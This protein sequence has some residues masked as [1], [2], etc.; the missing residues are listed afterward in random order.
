[1]KQEMVKFWALLVLSIF[2]LSLVPVAI[3]NGDDDMDDDDEAF[4]DSRSVNSGKGKGIVSSVNGIDMKKGGSPDDNDLAASQDKVKKLLD[5]WGEIQRTR[6]D[7]IKYMKEI[8]NKESF[9]NGHAVYV[10]KFVV[11][12]TQHIKIRLESI[13]A[14]MSKDAEFIKSHPKIL[15]TIKE[16]VAKD[17]AVEQVLM[18]ILSDGTVTRDEWTQQAVPAFKSIRLIIKEIK[19]NKDFGDWRERRSR[20]VAISVA[21]KIEKKREK[22]KEAMLKKNIDPKTIEERMK[23]IDDEVK[24]LR[25]ASQDGPES[26][27][28]I[29][30]SL[31]SIKKAL[32]V[33]VMKKSIKSADS[34]L[35]QINEK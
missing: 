30:G 19:N 15:S 34:K 23:L 3:A 32:Q 12:V 26:E 13:A 17:M 24:K 11:Y 18:G 5:N 22:M 21:D 31:E 27:S 35:K 7:S 14:Q 6:E 20:D 10:I 29:K 1:M 28:K 2:I 4:D 33:K 9:D 8:K 16:L 25:E